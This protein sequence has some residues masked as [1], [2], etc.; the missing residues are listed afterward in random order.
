MAKTSKSSSKPK[1]SASSTKKVTTKVYTKSSITKTVL[2]RRPVFIIVVILFAVLGTWLIAGGHALTPNDNLSEAID[3]PARG[4][5]YNGRKLATSGSC[6]GTFESNVSH[7]NGQ[8][9]CEHPDPGPEGVD[10]RERI[11]HIDADLAAQVAKDATTPALSADANEVSPTAAADVLAFGSLS[12]VSPVNWP[13]L[14]TGVDGVRTQ[15]VYVYPYGAT[16]RISTLRP[17][18]ETIAR[19]T[20]AVFH[21]TG[22]ASGGIRNV[23]YVTNSACTLS[24]ASV[25][26]SGSI[27]DGNNVITQLR[28]KGYASNYRK[29]LVEID[30]NYTSNSCGYG[31]FYPDTRPTQ[32]NYNNSGDLIALSWRNCWNYTEPHELMH[33]MGAVQSGAPYSTTR[34][35]CYDQHDVMCY[36]DGSGKTMIQRCTSTVNQ[37]RF[38]CYSDTYFRAA[39]AT[40]WLATHWNTANNRFLSH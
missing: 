29:Y 16:N 6:K 12:Q 36:N 8:K 31:Q 20:N 3:D 10:V 2:Y 13:C 23:R 21:N 19:R 4:L 30:A 25:A 27:V 7:A 15:M 18:F 1:P 22:V 9:S 38:D 17:S 28:A 32:D 33:T 11:K 40:G 34:G 39:G 26:I 24:I 14:G 35:H 5:V 37:W